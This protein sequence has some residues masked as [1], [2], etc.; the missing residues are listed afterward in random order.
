MGIVGALIS[1]ILV[2]GAHARNHIAIL[3][4][5]IIS[6]L[7]FIGLVIFAIFVSL[8][9]FGIFKLVDAA[10]EGKYDRLFMISLT[11]SLCP[12]YGLFFKKTLGRKQN[13]TTPSYY[14]FQAKD[15]HYVH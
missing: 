9:L 14:I 4:W 13:I 8:L 1:A 6:I 12:V 3:I 2:Y 15:M 5:M 7:H 10:T 11:F